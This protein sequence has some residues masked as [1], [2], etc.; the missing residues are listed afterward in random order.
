MQ[1]QQ[2][3][4]KQAEASDADQQVGRITRDGKAVAPEIIA[5][6][7]AQLLDL[8]ADDKLLDVCC[9]NGALTHLLAKKAAFC[10]GVDLSP[11]QIEL[12]KN[13]YPA[14]DWHCLPAQEVTQLSRQYHKIALYFSFQ[15]FT[16]DAEALAVLQA[17][18]SVLLPGGRILLGDIP[19]A[20]HW[21][22][23]Y[24]SWW[25][26]LR[27]LWHRLLSREDMGRF[28]RQ[29]DLARLAQ[30]AGLNIRFLAEPAELPFAWYRFDA[31]L[32]HQLPG[33]TA[34]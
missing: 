1:W 27:W 29:I 32:E 3:W 19:D 22:T 26:R 14:G 28:W 25:A 23:Y 31:I 12:A 16:R 4:D 24:G 17:L 20:A 7:I 30:Q 5:A 9:G 10:S 15:Y 13:R 21:W 2:F 34:N 8:Q 11:K 18:K 33:K 6:H